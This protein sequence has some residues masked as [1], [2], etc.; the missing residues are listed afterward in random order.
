MIIFFN[1]HLG[2]SLTPREVMQPNWQALWRRGSIKGY[3][4][5]LKN[6]SFFSSQNNR[7]NLNFEKSKT[8]VSINT[9]PTKLNIPPNLRKINE[10]LLNYFGTTINNT[11]FIY[12]SRFFTLNYLNLRPFENWALVDELMIKAE[13][14]LLSSSISKIFCIFLILFI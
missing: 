6:V 4:W 5:S 2:K 12:I 13:I 7:T 3:Y 10:I 1:L 9:H 8:L 11:I 14:I